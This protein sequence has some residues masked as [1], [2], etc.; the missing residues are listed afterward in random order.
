MTNHLTT[1]PNKTNS[2]DCNF[3]Q[4][5]QVDQGTLQYSMK[6]PITQVKVVPHLPGAWGANLS[7]TGQDPR[8]ASP[9]GTACGSALQS[10]TGQAHGRTAPEAGS[11]P[12]PG[13]STRPCPR[14]HRARKQGQDCCRTGRAGTPGAGR[15]PGN[16]GQ[17][18]G[19][20]GQRALR[21]LRLLPEARQEGRGRRVTWRP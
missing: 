7:Q 3:Q 12:T 17:G 16:T 8:T 5:P 20:G 11:H 6:Q 1:G 15:R 2:R 19:L 4:R 21:S 14:L 13:Q 10:P 9:R 18:E